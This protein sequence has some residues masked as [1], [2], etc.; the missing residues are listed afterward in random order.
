MIVESRPRSSLPVLVV[1]LLLA[2]LGAV[3][4]APAAAEIQ[5][6]VIECGE[7]T[8]TGNP[9]ILV[10]NVGWETGDIHTNAPLV[11]G[12]AKDYASYID[13]PVNEWF[14]A[15]APGIWQAYQ[16][17]AA[18]DYMIAAPHFQDPANDKICDNGQWFSEVRGGA[19]AA[20]KAH[21]LTPSNY[22]I[23]AVTWPR[24]FC[25]FLG[26]HLGNG[27]G[28]ARK[29]NTP[30]HELGH[31]LGLPHA[32][33]LECFGPNGPGTAVPLSNNCVVND[34]N[35][36]FDV[37]GSGNGAFNAIYAKAL[38]WMNNQYADVV[39]SE[40]VSSFSLKPFTALPHGTRAIRLQDGPTT[41]WIEYRRPIG[42]DAAGGFDPSLLIHREVLSVGVPQS[43][44]LDMTPSTRFFGD[45]GLPVGATWAN[46]LGTMQI[47]NVSATESGAIVQISPQRISVPDLIRKTKAQ[48]EAALAAVGLK[49][50]GSEQ[51]NDPSCDFIN[52]VKTQNPGVG[53]Q[54]F[55][56]TSV[57]VTIGKM[58][59]KHPCQ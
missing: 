14:A 6:C 56:G 1:V 24:A 47:T 32:H 23:I 55:P 9:S 49:F 36:P 13:G 37:M 50:G 27:I 57:S 33:T 51:V 39:A 35:D 8:P 18:G 2:A 31:L 48:A 11:Q 54:V 4:A 38:G 20:A 17:A 3:A 29:S 5:P 22:D 44:L 28:L 12:G 15:S 53:T 58:D 40:F 25:S 16:V 26:I 59:P 10:I 46:P 19:E 43:Q 34:V 21:G 42:I 52:V 45:A 30:M 7:E 41:L